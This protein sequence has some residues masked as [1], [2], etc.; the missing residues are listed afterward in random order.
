[1]H[2]HPALSRCCGVSSKNDRPTKVGAIGW[3]VAETR[4]YD[5]LVCSLQPVLLHDGVAG[6]EHV[7]VVGVTLARLRLDDLDLHLC[8]ARL[9]LD[10]LDLHLCLELSTTTNDN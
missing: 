6:L 5:P 4:C 3:Y 10:D 9:R 8:L 7:P 2:K 1:M